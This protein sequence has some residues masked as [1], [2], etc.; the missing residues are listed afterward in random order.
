MSGALLT[1]G[2][3]GLCGHSL[4]D[5]LIFWQNFAKYIKNFFFFLNWKDCC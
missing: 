1:T 4:L 5:S 2:I 3:P